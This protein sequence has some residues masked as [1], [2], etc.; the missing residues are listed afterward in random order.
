M[1]AHTNMHVDTHDLQHTQAHL[2][3]LE[4]VH[5]SM[6]SA[7]KT[8]S[9]TIWENHNTGRVKP[10]SR[11]KLILPVRVLITPLPSGS[12]RSKETC[13]TELGCSMMEKALPAPWCPSCHLSHQQNWQST[14]KWNKEGGPPTGH[15]VRT[16]ASAGMTA[17]GRAPGTDTFS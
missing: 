8:F 4:S 11:K 3:T 13:E 2:C 7:F 12:S 9:N 17:N 14:G 1:C 15:L 10:S 16:N 5:I 6:S